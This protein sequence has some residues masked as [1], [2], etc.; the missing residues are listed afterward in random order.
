MGPSHPPRSWHQ[1]SCSSPGPQ[2]VLKHESDASARSPLVA[3][4]ADPDLDVRIQGPALAALHQ[5]CGLVVQV[6]QAHTTCLHRGGSICV[7]VLSCS[8]RRSAAALP[9]AQLLIVQEIEPGLR[10]VGVVQ[11]NVAQ[12]LW[13]AMSLQWSTMWHSTW[14]AM[15]QWSTMWHST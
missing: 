1:L 5:L 9:H 2:A 10:G 3:C 8:S 11:H 15:L 6:V 4:V 14:S 7:P 12:H 13:S